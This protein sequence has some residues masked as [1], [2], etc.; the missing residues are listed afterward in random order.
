[1][2]EVHA[3]NIH[4]NVCSNVLSVSRWS[5]GKFYSIGLPKE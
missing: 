4:H 5:A 2:G 3:S 1:M